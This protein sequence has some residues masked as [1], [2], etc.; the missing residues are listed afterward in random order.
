MNIIS[1][2]CL[3]GFI[4]KYAGLQYENP[5]I[6]TAFNG[7]SL[8]YIL[9]NY[10]TIN[11]SKI[12]LHDVSRHHGYNLV[13]DDKLDMKCWS[14]YKYDPTAATPIKRGDSIYSNNIGQ[15]ILDT[16]TKRLSRMKT[17]PIF[18]LYWWKG[19]ST[20]TPEY[21]KTAPPTND[22][23]YLT[24]LISQKFPY[25]TLILCPYKSLDHFHGS[26]V[27][28]LYE[29]NCEFPRRSPAFAA[30]KRL[31]DIISFANET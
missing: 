7:S 22:Y 25:K 31:D 20:G 24:A 1:N 14:H 16:Y 11:F 21:W 10:D 4:Y 13:I 27:T 26:G 8:E 30:K 15:Y 5:F 29:D 12:W 9:F 18:V 19:L 23:Q 28:C 17:A 3:G 6:W 2:N